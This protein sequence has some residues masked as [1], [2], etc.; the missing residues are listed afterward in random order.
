MSLS[1][2]DMY[3][4]VLDAQSSINQASK[5]ISKM[6]NLIAGKLQGNKVSHYT[7]CK[8]KKELANFNMQTGIW[9]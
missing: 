3:H 4:A 1:F 5:H 8:L 9:K 2:S 6:A 7:L